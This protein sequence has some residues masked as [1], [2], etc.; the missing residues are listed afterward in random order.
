MISI[1]IKDEGLFEYESVCTDNRHAMPINRNYYNESDCLCHAWVRIG[2]IS[3]KEFNNLYKNLGM[4]LSSHKT[5]VSDPK[6][7]E[8]E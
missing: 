5:T 8:S 6:E 1:D 3:G 7:G 2:G 4:N